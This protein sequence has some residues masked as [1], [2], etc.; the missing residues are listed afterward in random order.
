MRLFELLSAHALSLRMYMKAGCQK[1][2]HVA[3]GQR[4]TSHPT[5]VRHI[6]KLETV[7]VV[8]LSHHAVNVPVPDVGTS[9]G[10]E[11][12]AFSE[13]PMQGSAP[14]A[15]GLLH[16]ARRTSSSVNGSRLSGV[17]GISDPP[18][19]PPGGI[20]TRHFGPQISRQAMQVMHA[21]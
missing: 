7:P 19:T 16:R 20:A 10:S 13:R 2:V 21:A 3:D 17:N 4:R 6:C 1:Y 18:V 12:E 15:S 8:M 14:A 5:F 9:P 11:A